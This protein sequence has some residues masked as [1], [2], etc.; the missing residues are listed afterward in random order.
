MQKI[1]VSKMN[2]TK[3]FSV[4][5]FLIAVALAYFLVD[6]VKSKIDQDQLIA[7]QEALVIDK[8]KMIRD[9]EIAFQAVHGKYT[10]NWDSLISFVDTGRVYL[11]ERK[12]T[13]ITLE[14]GA[15]SVNIEIDTLGYVPVKDSLFVIKNNVKALIDGVVEK[16]NVSEGQTVEKKDVLAE[17]RS[18]QSRRSTKLRAGNAGTIE[19]VYVK[20]GEEVTKE[21]AVVKLIWPRIED[22]SRLPYIPGTDKKFELFAG[23]IEKGGLT[24]SVFEAKDT[25]PINP[26]RLEGGIK[27]P[28]KVGS[29]IDVSTS[30]NW[31]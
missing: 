26:D 19:R 3:I 22:L 13:V 9:A 29:R 28:L 10:G 11:I 31:E 27:E 18:S 4:V 8:L 20:D 23:Q 30:G 16:V 14:Y 15:D 2:L 6:S 7:D 1:N 12:E 24:V 21:D 5:F 25:N 17:L